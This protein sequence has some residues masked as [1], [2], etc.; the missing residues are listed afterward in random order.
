MVNTTLNLGETG[1]CRDSHNLL[2]ESRLNRRIL[3]LTPRPFLS[4]GNH[5][6]SRPRHALRQG[7][8]AASNKTGSRKSVG[9]IA[10]PVLISF[11]LGTS[12]VKP[13][14]WNMIH[15]RYIQPPLPRTTKAW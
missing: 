9:C 8:Q 11:S 13:A 1:T 7:S 6:A 2:N 14:I 12:K 4:L 10:R 3:A 15:D 5:R